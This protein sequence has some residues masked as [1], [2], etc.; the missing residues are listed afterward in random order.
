[1]E[2]AADDRPGGGG[3]ALPIGVD[4]VV[5]AGLGD[6]VLPAIDGAGLRERVVVEERAV[7]LVEDADVAAVEG[8]VANS[9]DREGVNG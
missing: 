6:A 5:A 8:K 7:A 1:M 3:V 4:D 9:G 2:V